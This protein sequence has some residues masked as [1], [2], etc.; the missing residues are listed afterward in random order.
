MWRTCRCRITF[1]S[2]TRY[3]CRTRPAVMLRNSS[4]RRKCLLLSVWSTGVLSSSK[5]T[6]ERERLNYLQSQAWW[7]RDATTARSSW[8]F[9]LLCMPSKLSTSSQTQTPSRF[10]QLIAGT[11]ILVYLIIVLLR[12]LWM[13]SATLAH[14]KIRPVLVLRVPSVVRPSMSPRFVAWTRLLPYSP[15]A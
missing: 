6:A 5:S 13:R 15:L 1:K 14:V 12:S 11:E 8:P 3:T 7:W 4:R 2:V 10:D 9:A